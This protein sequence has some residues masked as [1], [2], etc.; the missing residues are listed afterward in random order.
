[1]VSLEGDLSGQSGLP[2][3]EVWLINP[4]TDKFETPVDG[5]GFIDVPVLI[6][7]VKDTIDPEYVW[8]KNLSVHHLYWKEDWYS[9]RFMGMD[10]QKFRNLSPHKALVPRVFENWLHAVTI[11]PDVPDPFMMQQR[12]E[13]WTQ[14]RSLFDSA[15]E[16]I[17]WERRARRREVLIEE[18][19]AVL[20]AEF[21]GEDKIGREIISRILGKHFTGFAMNVNRFLSLPEEH[22][23]LEQLS[24]S[25]HDVANL[26]G[27]LVVPQTLKL[28]SAVAA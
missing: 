18:N 4:K 7:A 27:K 11:P 22:R 3:E 5:R 16:V 26:L 6:Q 2:P 9:S 23:P 12:I 10:A 8:P 15:R 17:R 13:A 14:A 24:D 20:P 1:M 19:P 28:T 25:P 21:N